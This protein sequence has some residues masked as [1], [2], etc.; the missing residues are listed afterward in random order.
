MLPSRDLFRRIV[1]LFFETYKYAPVEISAGFIG[2][3]SF[4]LVKIF[5]NFSVGEEHHR[6]YR[7]TLPRSSL[8]PTLSTRLTSSISASNL[9]PR[10]SNFYFSSFRMDCSEKWWSKRRRSPSSTFHP[11]VSRRLLLF[12]NMVRSQNPTSPSSLMRLPRK[13]V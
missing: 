3:D 2:S 1:D 5:S 8:S 4:V 7:K 12:G 9:F 6:L 11:L 10:L 13:K